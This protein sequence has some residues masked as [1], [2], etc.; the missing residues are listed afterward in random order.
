MRRAALAL[1][2]ATGHAASASPWTVSLEGGAE[3][4]SNVERVE[5]GTGLDIA[6]IAAAVG[7]LGGRLEHADR[8]AGGA[9][10]FNLSGLGRYVLGNDAASPENVALIAGDLRWLHPV[11]DRPVSVGFALTGADAIAITDPIGNRTFRNLGGDA[12]LL[13]RPS[14]ERK[15]TLA[16][17][18]R[19]FVYKP[20]RQFDWTGPVA[21][22]RLDL[23]LWQAAGQ[24]KT[25][26]LAG[27]AGFEARTYNGNAFADSC[28]IG[29]AQAPTCFAPTTIVRRDR[30]QRVGVELTWVGDF[31]AALGYQVT[32]VDSNSYGQSLVRHRATLSGTTELFWGI[33]ATGLVTLQID[34]YLNGL[35]VQSDFQHTSFTNLEDENRSSIQ[36]RL[37]RPITSTISAEMRGAIWRGIGDSMSD[38]FGRELLY[39]GL[40]YTN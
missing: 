29:E 31:V 4:D 39:A 15:L 13:I 12:L 30:V 23:V 35:L 20:D 24:T 7:R 5:T 34:R 18:G 9:Y 26:E 2:M 1:V 33:F 37:A 17:G 32:V 22:A 28:A 14:D 25:F 16:L 27:T 11:G 10:A 8:L 36:V 6:P 3:A 38:E 19:D 21:S 40:I